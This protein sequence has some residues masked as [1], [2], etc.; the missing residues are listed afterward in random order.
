MK[1]KKIPFILGC[2]FFIPTV[3]LLQ[4]TISQGDSNFAIA[5]GAIGL[6]AYQFLE[7]SKVLD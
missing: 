7:K 3:L 6:L 1:I 5:S 4:L 2:A